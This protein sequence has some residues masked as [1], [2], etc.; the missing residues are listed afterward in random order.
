MSDPMSEKLLRAVLR[1]TPRIS[2]DKRCP[3]E[4]QLAAYI[5]SEL[6]PELLSRLE[7][8][9][10]ACKRC[11][12]AVGFG[13]RAQDTSQPTVVP[14][15][16]L[17]KARALGSTPRRPQAM[18]WR[19]GPLTAAACLT[20]ALVSY[21]RVP[22]PILQ[23]RTE[24][25]PEPAAPGGMDA[26][27]PCAPSQAPAP[28]RPAERKTVRNTTPGNQALQVESPREGARVA[29]SNFELRWTRVAAALFY[30]VQLLGADGTLL[31]QER[32][33]DVRIW[34]PA[35]VSL[36]AEASHYVLVRAHLAD[37]R[38]LKSRAVEFIPVATK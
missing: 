36:V 26:A 31:W 14:P 16:L 8:H 38:I 27:V 17:Q 4:R 19:R 28:P 9:L 23:I 33:E 22:E 2:W 11:S 3:N 13:V 15:A 7:S 18:G 32:V 5:D 35:K 20:G 30:E 21:L 24:S 10:A 6:D 25:V 34:L 29:A 37:G 12:A 1:A